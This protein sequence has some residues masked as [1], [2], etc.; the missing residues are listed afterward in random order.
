MGNI[1]DRGA[2][3][4][5]LDVGDVDPSVVADPEPVDCNVDRSE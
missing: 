4:A 2:T 5:I 1:E 3:G